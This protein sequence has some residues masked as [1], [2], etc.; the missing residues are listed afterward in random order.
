MTTLNGKID[1]NMNNLVEMQDPNS[2]NKVPKGFNEKLMMFQQMDHAG[3]GGGL[4]GIESHAQSSNNVI[5][6]KDT[7]TLVDPREDETDMPF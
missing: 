2:R 3:I 5:S 6:S 1:L 4:L 7:P